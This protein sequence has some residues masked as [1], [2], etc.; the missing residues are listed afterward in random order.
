MATETEGVDQLQD[1]NLPGVRYRIGNG[2]GV[3]RS[4]FRQTAEIFAGRGVNLFWFNSGSGKLL[5]PFAPYSID[6][7]RI[8]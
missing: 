1:F 2:C 3:A 4:V 5:E 6:R 7:V 8:G